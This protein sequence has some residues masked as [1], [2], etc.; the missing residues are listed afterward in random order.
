MTQTWRK[1][2]GGLSSSA[3][4][5]RGG[6]TALHGDGHAGR[7]S[8]PA[9]N[10]PRPLGTA[11]GILTLGS[12]PARA[13]SAWLHGSAGDE[14][15]PL[16]AACHPALDDVLLTT[17]PDEPARLGY[18][19]PRLLGYVEDCAPATGSRGVEPPALLWTRRWG[20]APS[21]SSRA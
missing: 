18:R 10:G 9:A 4:D 8:G 17:D 5:G 1:G 21:A 13:A 6:E 7:G 14:R 15:L 12:P 11:G 16:F 20:R 2:L 3:G 19:R